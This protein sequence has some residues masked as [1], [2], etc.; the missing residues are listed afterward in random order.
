MPLVELVRVVAADGVRLDGAMR[1][2]DSSESA[3][4]AFV[5]HGTGGNFYSSAMLSTLGQRLAELGLWTVQAN[6]RGHDAMSSAHTPQGS[7]RL[8]G[9]YEIVADCVHDL[10][11]WAG[12]LRE[13]GCRRIVAVGHSLGA[14][15]CA[16]WLAQSQPDFVAAFVAVSA[17]RIV[18]S[19]L[20]QGPHGEAFLRDHAEAARLVAEGRPQQLMEI[21][22]PL[23]YVVTAAGFLDKYGREE[24]YDLLT[25]L[26]AVKCPWLATYA[27]REL[28]GPAFAGLPDA[29]RD[30][31]GDVA[32][33]GQTDHFYTGAHRELADHIERWLRKRLG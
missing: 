30:R 25:A 32:I 18:Y 26:G 31:G 23:P 15:K 33:V 27:E 1:A 24:R 14:L 5:V 9:A 22:F 29:C 11:A 16:Y 2:P 21:A 6:T 4:G 20:S 8:G 7:R 17:P 19:V 3:D 13:R 28:P 10:A 12:F